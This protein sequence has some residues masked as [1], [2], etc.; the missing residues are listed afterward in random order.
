MTEISREWGMITPEIK[1]QLEH[2][3]AISAE[4]N[5]Q[6]INVIF[7]AKKNGKGPHAAYSLT[8]NSTGKII[9]ET[10]GIGRTEDDALEAAVGMVAHRALGKELRGTREEN[11]VTKSGE[12][13]MRTSVYVAD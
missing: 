1:D 2:N 3:P 11:I 9:S 13:A 6:V 7:D 5:G 4:V 8:R 10:V 12:N